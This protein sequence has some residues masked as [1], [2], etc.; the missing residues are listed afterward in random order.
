VQHKLSGVKPTA[1][2]TIGN[3]NKFLRVDGWYYPSYINKNDPSISNAHIKPIMVL[4]SINANGSV[5]NENWL[6]AFIKKKSGRE[7]MHFMVTASQYG[8]YSFVLA[9]V[10]LP[11]LYQGILSCLF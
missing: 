1:T 2:F 6:G 9:D 11:W 4:N 8:H 5:N 7:E 10:W 3:I